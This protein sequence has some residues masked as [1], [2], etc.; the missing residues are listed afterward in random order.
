MT[1]EDLGGEWVRNGDVVHA[2]T[3]TRKGKRWLPWNYAYGM[4][5]DRVTAVMDGRPWLRWCRYCRP[6]P[7][8]AA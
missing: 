7:E 1:I 4:N 8:D 6:G 5:A 2:R 3:C